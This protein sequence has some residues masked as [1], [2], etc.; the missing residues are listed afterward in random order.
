M[1]INALE[2]DVWRQ[3]ENQE[4][5]LGRVL[6]RHDVL[7]EVE[8]CE[9]WQIKS[10]PCLASLLHRSIGETLYGRTALIHC[11]GEPAIEL[12]E[13]VAPVSMG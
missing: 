5:P 11:D 9:L 3:I 13:V 4:V 6:I 7:R 10:G 12:L 8:L 1:N 2:E